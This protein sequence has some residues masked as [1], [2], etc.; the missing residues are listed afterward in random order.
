MPFFTHFILF[1]ITYKIAVNRYLKS[2]EFI[3]TTLLEGLRQLKQ[4]K[5]TSYQIKFVDVLVGLICAFLY[6][7]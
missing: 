4:L 2:R 3:V 7:T 6:I 1:I 5:F